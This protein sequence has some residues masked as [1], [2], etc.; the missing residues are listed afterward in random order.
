M[1][2][3]PEDHPA[4]SDVPARAAGTDDW[5]M[6][7]LID[8]LPP[9]IGSAVRHVRQPS[10]R[11]LRVPAGIALTFG[12]LVG[13]LPVVGFWMLPLG[14]AV[15]ADD[16]PPLRSARSRVLDWIERTRPHWLEQR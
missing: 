16:L 6:E 4:M 8:K 3:S 11:Y 14:L 15:L 5:R 2:P 7:R 1:T 10:A 12:G 9:R 13:F